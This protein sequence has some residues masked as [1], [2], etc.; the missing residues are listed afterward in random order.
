MN[1]NYSHIH[2]LDHVVS[3]F[4]VCLYYDRWHQKLS[5]KIHENALKALVN[6]VVD[7]FKK[8]NAND[9]AG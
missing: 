9:F 8:S 2:S 5:K 3:I 1:G 7:R 6:I 4:K